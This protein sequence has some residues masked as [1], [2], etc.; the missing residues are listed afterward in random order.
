MTSRRTLDPR[1]AG[2]NPT[3]GCATVNAAMLHRAIPCIGLA[4]LILLSGASAATATSGLRGTVVLSPT[5]PVCIENE[6]CS[7]PAPGIVMSFSRKGRLVGRT[8]TGIDG[9]YRIVLG[10]GRYAV[11]FTPRRAPH[12]LAP[13]LVT[14]VSGAVRRVDFE[15][16]T[17]LR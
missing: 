6:P 2:N 8:T 9:S 14:V 16:D 3:F 13:M 11:A 5:R 15:I 1:G 17:G 10:P 12:T 4:S 7:K